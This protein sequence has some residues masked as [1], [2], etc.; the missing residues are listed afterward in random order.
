MLGRGFICVQIRMKNQTLIDFNMLDLIM[1]WYF[2]RFCILTLFLIGSHQLTSAKKQIS[3]L[4]S[5]FF[6]RGEQL[7]QKIPHPFSYVIFI[8]N[9][10]LVIYQLTK[11]Q[12][13][14]YVLIFSIFWYISRQIF[15]GGPL[16]TMFIFLEARQSE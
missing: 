8:E 2:N 6:G 1:Y 4:P 13:H 11:K 9:I 16:I 10:Y 3:Y 12:T 14:R 5:I 7:R 15:F